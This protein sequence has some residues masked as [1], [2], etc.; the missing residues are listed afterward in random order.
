PPI[1]PP[2]RWRCVTRW[3]RGT[4]TS[5][6]SWPSARCAAR[7]RTW[8]RRVEEATMIGEP[9]PRVDGPLKVAGRA[10]YAYEHWEADQP[11]YGFIVGATIGTGRITRIDTEAAERA[12]GVHL[13]MTHH[14][15]PAQ[16]EPD[17]SISFEF[18]RAYPALS[19]PDV[20]HYGAPVA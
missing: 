7:W 15:A 17:R 13:V 11:V 6:S 18:W 14:N 3:G 8:P 16:G 10:T 19:G 1:A 5:R 20:R 2:P 12:P 9:L 4:T